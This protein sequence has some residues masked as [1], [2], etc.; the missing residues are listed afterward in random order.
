MPLKTFDIYRVACGMA[1][2]LAIWS[3]PHFVVWKLQLRRA[4]KVA[5]TIIFALGILY[6]SNPLIN[7]G[8]KL[9]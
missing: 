1:I 5:I 9:D 4:H 7:K 6:F 8:S 3:L 2:D